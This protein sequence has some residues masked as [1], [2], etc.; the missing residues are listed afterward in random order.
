MLKF[1]IKNIIFLSTLNASLGFSDSPQ[2][3]SGRDLYMM[4]QVPTLSKIYA[5][6]DEVRASRFTKLF[7]RYLESNPAL[8]AYFSELKREDLDTKVEEYLVEKFGESI[9]T[10][11]ASGKYK[12]FDTEN[13][14]NINSEVKNWNSSWSWSKAFDA[15]AINTHILAKDLTHVAKGKSQTV[16]YYFQGNQKYFV[17]TVN[18]DFRKN[19]AYYLIN[20]EFRFPFFPKFELVWIRGGA[21]EGPGIRSA[22]APGSFPGIDTSF[23]RVVVGLENIFSTC[24]LNFIQGALFFTTYTDAHGDNFSIQKSGA[25]KG[26]YF[27]DFDKGFTLEVSSNYVFTAPRVTEPREFCAAL[28]NFTTERAKKLLGHVLTPSELSLLDLRRQVLLDGCP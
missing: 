27:V 22:E 25:G 7:E 8:P 1:S 12:N 20:S 11:R 14:K 4:V 24:Y 9:A 28:G 17:R 3:P 6:G 23:E 16:Y 15:N 2:F 18:P 13:V 10:I 19:L 21:I 5:D 26:I